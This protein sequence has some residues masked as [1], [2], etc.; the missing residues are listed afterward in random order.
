VQK[1]LGW[2]PENIVKRG[3]ANPLGINVNNVVS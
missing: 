3:F 2:N 1:V